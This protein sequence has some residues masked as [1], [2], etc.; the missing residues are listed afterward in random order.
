MERKE[1]SALGLT[2][3]NTGRPCKHGHIA[4]RRVKDRKCSACELVAIN[5]YRNENKEHIDKIKKD[6]YERNKE[7]H[8]AQKREYRQANKGKINALVAARKQH[9]KE[10]TPSWVGKEEMWLIKEIYDLA[11][12]RTKMTGRQ[13]HVDHIVPLQGRL[14]SGLHIPENMQVIPAIINITKKNKFGVEYGQ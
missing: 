8:L 5:I 10:R 12:L 7:H 11:S 14:V 2:H 6:S 4:N 3:Y 13:W 9:I 1:A